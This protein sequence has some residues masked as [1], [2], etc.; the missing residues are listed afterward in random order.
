MAV[1]DKIA[2][3]AAPHLQPGE[4]VQGVLFGQ[5]ASNYLILLA[6]VVF[7]AM[8]EFRTIVATDRRI[9]VLD[10]GRWSGTKA[11]AVVV[12]LPRTTK[13][14][15]WTGNVWHKTTLGSETLRI[16]RRFKGDIEAIDRG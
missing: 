9:L 7:Y 3:N 14:G 16:H 1:R 13:L 15:P 11:K 6:V 12:E 2:A 5:T 4:T 8:N 10:S